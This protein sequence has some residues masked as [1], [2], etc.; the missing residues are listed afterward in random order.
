MLKDLLRLIGLLSV[1]VIGGNLIALCQ[2]IAT[3]MPDYMTLL[4]IICML[5]ILWVQ[6]IKLVKNNGGI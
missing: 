4:I 2:K 3:S 5:V 1:V 6:V